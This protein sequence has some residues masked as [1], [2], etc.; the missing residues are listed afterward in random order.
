MK[1]IVFFVVVEKRCEHDVVESVDS[2][3]VK[4]FAATIIV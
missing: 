4:I 3:A 2:R 1:L